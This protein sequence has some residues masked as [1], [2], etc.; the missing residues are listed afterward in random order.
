MLPRLFYGILWLLS[1]ICF[2][3]YFRISISGREHI[4][5]G[6]PYII[7]ANHESFLD[8]I[9]VALIK[10]KV[11]VF[12]AMDGVFRTPVFGWIVSRLPVIRVFPGTPD[13]RALREA[14]TALNDGFT[15]GIFPEGTRNDGMTTYTFKG[16][17]GFLACR[18]GSTILPVGIKGSHRAFGKKSII[19]KPCRIAVRIGAP[20]PFEELKTRIEPPGM[21]RKISRF[22]QDVLERM[23]YSE[24]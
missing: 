12:M 14:V 10:W 18:T 4:P 16:G 21:A 13:R 15:V 20:I 7:V 6:M 17:A 19:P 9:C 11:T 5:E 2:K 1:W 3:L 23:V 24:Q 22:L 8:P